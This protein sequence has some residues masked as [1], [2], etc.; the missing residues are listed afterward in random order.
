SEAEDCLTAG[1]IGSWHTLYVMDPDGTDERRLTRT[2]GQFAAWSPDGRHILFAPGLNVIRPD[3][4]GLT[5]I[6]PEDLPPEPL[7]PDWIGA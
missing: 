5:R 7:F 1:D 4:T 3:G 2:F 6:P